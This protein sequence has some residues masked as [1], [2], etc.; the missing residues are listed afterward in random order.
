MT[1]CNV[2]DYMKAGV[3]AHLIG[4]G[5]VSMAPLAEVLAGMGMLI[6]GSDFKES[7]TVTHLRSL[8]IPVT[9]GHFAENVD[10]AEL[11]IRTA[12]IH[13]DNPEIS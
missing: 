12:A 6:T 10:G 7:A 11:I 4:I 3:R 9:I 13:D 2:H 5:G 8:G 1:K